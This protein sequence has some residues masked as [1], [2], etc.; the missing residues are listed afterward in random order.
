MIKCVFPLIEELNAFLCVYG[1]V[2][3]FDKMMKENSNPVD[4]SVAHI[5]LYVCSL[6]GMS[7]G[8]IGY[9]AHYWYDTP[10]LFDAFF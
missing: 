4:G 8:C 7:G 2:Y 3:N 1:C 9:I 6:L 10:T 5:L